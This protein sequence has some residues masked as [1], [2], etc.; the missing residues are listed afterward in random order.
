MFRFPLNHGLSNPI[1]GKARPALRLLLLTTSFLALPALLAIPQ[2]AA[3]QVGEQSSTSPQPS[4]GGPPQNAGAGALSDQRIVVRVNE[5]NVP[6]SVLDKRGVPVI[7]LKEKDF[8]IYEEGQRQKIKYLYRGERPPLRIGLVLDTSNTARPQLE[9]E[10]DSAAEFAFNMLQG[11]SSRNRIFLQTFDS[12]SSIVQDF[13]SDPNTLNEQIRKL[14]AGGGKALYDAIYFACKEQMMPLGAPRETRRVLVVISD[15]MDVQS[16]HTMDEAVSM[17]RHAETMIYTIGNAPWGFNNYGKK[18]LID[19]A[20][21]T[22]GASLFPREET[23]G[24][25]MQTG[26]FSH[27]Q[28]GDTSQN[29]GLGAGT[30]VYSSQRLI[31]IADS[32]ESIQRELNDQ[33]NI[34]YTP[35]NQAMDGSYRAIKVVALRKG[36]EVRSK[37][38]YFATQ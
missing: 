2:A 13:T 21:L 34:G 32:L 22:G 14:K 1:C 10:K 7:D 26:Y 5:V 36:V 31:A 6:V 27:G 17:A 18:T 28:I 15:G 16:E 29:K 8:E 24:T 4:A 19:L 38:G 33:Y 37:P 35:T 3:P 12:S 25:D 30:G 9:F 20:E 23:P 11:R